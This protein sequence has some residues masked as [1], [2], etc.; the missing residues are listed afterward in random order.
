MFDL[1]EFIMTL[2]DEFSIEEWLNIDDEEANMRIRSNIY[3]LGYESN[4]CIASLGFMWIYTALF[5]IRVVLFCIFWLI[6]KPLLKY[7]VPIHECKCL[8]VW[9]NY[10]Y[11][12]IFCNEFL[13]I[14]IEGLI[15]FLVVANIHINPD[16]DFAGKTASL[17]FIIIYLVCSCIIL[18]PLAFG[19]CVA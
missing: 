12:A 8:K 17:F 7:K 2:T 1:T 6:S 11:R 5:F 3:D 18:P 4:N 15:E 10:E 19:F 13:R 14:F 9:Y 16:Y